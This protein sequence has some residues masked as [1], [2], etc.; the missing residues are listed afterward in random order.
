[1]VRGVVYVSDGSRLYALSAATGARRW[2][3]PAGGHPLSSPAVLN[4]TVYT[5][6]GNGTVYALNAATGALRWRVKLRTAVDAS[7][8]VADGA[9]YVPGGNRASCTR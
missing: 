1:M 6:T 8:A 9:V 7:L 5:V 2:T 3:Y 4:R